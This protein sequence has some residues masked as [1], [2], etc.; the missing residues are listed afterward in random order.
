[1]A[2]FSY[3]KQN[4]EE[5]GLPEEEETEVSDQEG[6]GGQ[7]G[8]VRPILIIAGVVAV[9]VGAWY[10]A[11]PLFFMPSSPPAGPTRPI[12]PV[13][14][15]KAPG[16]VAPTNES[17]PT[18][19]APTKTP[20]AEE[21]RPAS[22]V[23]PTKMATPISPAKESV[24]GKVAVAPSAPEKGLAQEKTAP[25]AKTE[26]KATEKHTPKV[27]PTSFSLQ[28]GA[29]V[30]EENAE[31]LKRKLDVGGFPAVI[32]KGTVYVTK[33]I[34]TVG[35]PTE[36]REAEELSRRL[37]VDGFPSQLLT[38]G[39]RYTPQIGAF[40]NLDEAIDLARELQ[41]KNYRPKIVSKPATAVVYQVRYGKFDSRAAAV[42]RG[43]E[44]KGKGFSFLVVRE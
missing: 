5:E 26:V 25:P 20:T 10:L 19:A 40:F 13:P 28:M 23:P 15:A 38:V 12:P 18:P 43:E 35:E 14:P 41:K 31:A 21:P 3:H 1:M 34:V 17:A 42:R 22:P 4:T 36:K 16:P 9:L 32:R 7:A 29:M 33:Q 24:S 44:L 6:R 8:G 11:Q 30:L 27:A 37:N 39:G 2:R